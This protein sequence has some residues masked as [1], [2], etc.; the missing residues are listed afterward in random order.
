[1]VDSVVLTEVLGHLQDAETDLAAE[2]TLRLIQSKDKAN[3]DP[4]RI[5]L[6]EAGLVPPLV[7]LLRD[8]NDVMREHAAGI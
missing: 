4:T 8:G 1:M 6:V 5:A 3:R 2:K 7:A